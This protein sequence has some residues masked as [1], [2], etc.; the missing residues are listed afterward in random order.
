MKLSNNAVGGLAIFLMLTTIL[1]SYV[2]VYRLEGVVSGKATASGTM[3]I[4]VNHA[5]QIS[6]GC[7]KT[8]YV[9][10]AYSC[11]ID[12]TDSDNAQS[13][14]Q[15]IAFTDNSAL[16]AIGATDGIISFTPG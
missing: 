16:F 7:G 15:N 10:I 3:R 1:S 5:P 12:A 9:G 6:Q 11:D 14:L 2:L 13:Q 4:C 8:G